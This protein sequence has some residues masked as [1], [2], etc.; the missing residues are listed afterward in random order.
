MILCHRC[1]S[2]DLAQLVERLRRGIAETPYS[3]SIGYS[4]AAGGAMP[5]SEMLR[6]SDEMMYAEKA[7]HY[8]DAGREHRKPE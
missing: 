2:D 7:R 3:C 8:A 6:Q 4:E 5:P 1:S